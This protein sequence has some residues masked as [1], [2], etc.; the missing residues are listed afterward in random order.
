MLYYRY[1]IKFFNDYNI[2]F[3]AALDGRSTKIAVVL[4]Q[5]ALQ[6]LPGAEDVVATERATALCGACDLTAKFLYIL[7]HADH[8]LGYISRFLIVFLFFYYLFLYS[9]FLKNILQYIHININFFSI[10]NID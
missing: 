7:P 6:P 9:S 3:R 10:Y 2:F 8:L 4:I 5:H 1:N